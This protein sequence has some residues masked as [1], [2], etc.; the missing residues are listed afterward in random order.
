MIVRRCIICGCEYGRVDDGRDRV[1][2]S[3]G[4]CPRDDCYARLQRQMGLPVEP[5][6]RR[7][8]TEGAPCCRP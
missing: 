8:Y 6:R 5:R 7:G 1:S 3:H 4:V 2:E